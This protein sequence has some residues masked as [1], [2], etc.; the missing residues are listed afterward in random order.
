M[1]RGLHRLVR[2]CVPVPGPVLGFVLSACTPIPAIDSGT[3]PPQGARADV[4][5]ALWCTGAGESPLAATLVGRPLAEAGPYIRSAQAAGIVV[6]IAEIAPDG[7]ASLL[8]IETTDMVTILHRDGVID[9][10]S[11]LPRDLCTGP[12]RGASGLC[13]GGRR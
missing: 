13:R 5:R 9:S 4:A 12:H 11:C 8:L 1:R 10:V 2:S 7:S 6:D 3:A